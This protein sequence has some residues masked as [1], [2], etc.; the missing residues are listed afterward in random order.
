MGD[1]GRRGD[2]VG[3]HPRAGEQERDRDREGECKEE[4]ERRE[5]A[6]RRRSIG[7]SLDIREAEMPRVEPLTAADG[8][9]VVGLGGRIPFPG[10][11]VFAT[12]D[13]CTEDAFS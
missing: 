2:R 6:R 3:E 4:G 1:G 10:I 9:A 11:D 7:A 8:K 12:L 13:F 5:D